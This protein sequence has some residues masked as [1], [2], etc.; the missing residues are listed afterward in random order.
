MFLN[1]RMK[2]GELNVKHLTKTEVTKIPHSLKALISLQ[3]YEPIQITL[4]KYI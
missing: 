3:S 4:N 2:D 1:Q